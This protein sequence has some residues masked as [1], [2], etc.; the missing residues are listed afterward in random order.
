[1]KKRIFFLTITEWLVI[2]A[3]FLVVGFV[4]MTTHDPNPVQH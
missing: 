3:I 4:L 2:G 1:M